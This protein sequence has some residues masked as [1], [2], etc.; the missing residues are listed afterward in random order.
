MA[1]AAAS[2][3][4]LRKRVVRGTWRRVGPSAGVGSS[5]EEAAEL[6]VVVDWERSVAPGEAGRRR[7]VRMVCRRTRGM[8]ATKVR[9]DMRTAVRK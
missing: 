7:R 4:S 8:K 5:E 2:Q 1:T 9:A 3:R 6:S